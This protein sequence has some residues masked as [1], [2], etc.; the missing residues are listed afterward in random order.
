MGKL[1]SWVTGTPSSADEATRKTLARA[2]AIQE[3]ETTE[4]Y[5]E[6]VG[7]YDRE[8]AWAKEQCTLDL[9]QDDTVVVRQYLKA[10]ELLYAFLTATHKN[11]AEAA[12]KI[13]KAA[14]GETPQTLEQYHEIVF[15]K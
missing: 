14:L 15:H 8:I 3:L 12:A 6:I 7:V 2:R 9:N 10:L 13:Q 5:A 1:L 11:G 4:G